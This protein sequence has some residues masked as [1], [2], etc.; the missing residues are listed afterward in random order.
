MMLNDNERARFVAYLDG[1]IATHKIM[2]EQI[3]KL[4][5]MDPVAKKFKMELAALQIVANRMRATETDSI[6]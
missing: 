6:G 2:I 1:E 3:M 5:G 4:P